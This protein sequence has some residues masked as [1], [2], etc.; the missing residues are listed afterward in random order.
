M[1][2]FELANLYDVPVRDVQLEGRF[3]G[4]KDL[5][6][7]SD[8]AQYQADEIGRRMILRSKARR[9]SIA[10]KLDTP[11]TETEFRGLSPIEQRV[12]AILER[13]N[14]TD[15]NPVVSHINLKLLREGLGMSLELAAGTIGVKAADLGR[16]EID[17]STPPWQVCDLLASYAV[18]MAAMWGFAQL[19]L[20]AQNFE[21]IVRVPKPSD[22][23]VS[24]A[25]QRRRPSRQSAR[26]R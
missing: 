25:P 10:P 26:T 21:E 1:K 5:R 22:I 6:P 4:L 11:R 8:L 23:P 2:V 14:R 16:W 9:P 17:P 19:R 20:N 24:T 13:P 15:E 3:I 7:N 18:H 12:M